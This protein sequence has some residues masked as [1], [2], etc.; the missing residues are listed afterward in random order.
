MSHEFK[1]LSSLLKLEWKFGPAHTAVAPED[2]WWSD[3][4]CT[5]SSPPQRALAPAQGDSGWRNAREYRCPLYPSVYLAHPVR[6]HCPC[7]NTPA[8]THART[9]WSIKTIWPL[10][11]YGSVIQRSVCLEEQQ[12]YMCRSQAPASGADI[13]HLTWH[14]HLCSPIQPC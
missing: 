10:I 4:P 5:C 7:G 3:S 2:E 12:I 14:S 11:H 9:L 13:M 8:Q 6:S 1:Y